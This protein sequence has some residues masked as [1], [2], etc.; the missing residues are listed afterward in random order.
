MNPVDQQTLALIGDGYAA[1]WGE[2]VD[3]YA[4][5]GTDD[6][7]AELDRVLAARAEREA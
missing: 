7:A 6:I 5:L 3:E 4:H 1:A 2:T